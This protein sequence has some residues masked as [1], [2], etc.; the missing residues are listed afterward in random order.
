MRRLKEVLGGG[1]K[2]RCGEVVAEEVK[3]CGEVLGGVRR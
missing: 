3:R 2:R 1:V